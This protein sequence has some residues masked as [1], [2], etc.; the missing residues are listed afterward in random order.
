[1]RRQWSP[2]SSSPSESCHLRDH[3]TGYKGWAFKGLCGLHRTF[4]ELCGLEGLY[5]LQV[6]LWRSRGLVTFGKVWCLQWALWSSTDFVVFNGLFDLHGTLWPSW[7]FTVFKRFCGFGVFKG[8]CGLQWIL[9]PSTDFL[10]LKWFLGLQWPCVL[11]QA[12]RPS[13]V[14]WITKCFLPLDLLCSLQLVLSV[15]FGFSKMSLLIGRHT[16]RNYIAT[17]EV[18]KLELD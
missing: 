10:V 4:V 5:A 13:R 1:M 8:L 9:C 12:L 3:Q 17:V 6:A 14:L 18:S 7:V 15:E 2:W 11:Q 16:V